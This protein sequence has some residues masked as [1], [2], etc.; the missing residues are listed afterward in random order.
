MR[1]C[2]ER[3]GIDRAAAPP[4][5]PTLDL[6]SYSAPAREAIAPLQRTA[7]A[8]STDPQAVGAL[9]RMLQAW[10]QLD[11][12]HQAYERAQAL[13]PHSFEWQYLDGVVLERLARHREAAQRFERALTES[14][15]Y[16]PARLALPEA[17]FEAGD[18]AG[19]RRLFEALTREPLAEPR[20]EFGLGRIDAAENHHPAAILHFERA[21]ALFPEW[22]AANYA[23]AQSYRVAGRMGD[24]RAALQRHAQYGARWPG[25]DDPVL[26]AVTALKDDAAAHLQRGI[27]LAAAGNLQGAIAEHEA[28]LSRDPKLAQA[29]ANL[30][31]LY[32]RAN[33][34]DKVEEHYRAT[35]A[36]GFS[37]ADAHYDYAVLL[38]QQQKWDLA[39]EA[40]RKAIAVNPL[41][42]P[43]HNNLGQLLERRQSFDAA[44]EEYA[45]ALDAQPTLRIARFNLG[46]MQIAQGRLDQAILTLDQLR[47]PVD[48]ATPRYLFGL[49]TAHVR[50]GH[51]DEGLKWGT[52]AKELALKYGQRELAEAIDRDLARLK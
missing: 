31:S 41:H 22:G 34:W 16:L 33:N 47:E 20:A 38:G 37:L 18:L 29:H 48:E 17:L 19:S 2:A 11:A 8:R 50:A 39:E 4:P 26:A 25:A 1:I 40:Y 27:S 44:A 45:R 9:A 14:P 13:A 7:A 35:V 12:A 30:I 51:K 23:L 32:G 28:A 42:A 3:A 36:L 24:A 10:E 5:L 43:A 46:R 15:G 6:P 49:S 52:A 21:L